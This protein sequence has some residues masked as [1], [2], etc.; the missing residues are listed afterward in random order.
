MNKYFPSFFTRLYSSLFVAIIFSAFVTFLVLDK[1]IE[2]D[3]W[4]DFVSDTM[5]MKNVVESERTEQQKSAAAFYSNLNTAVYPFDLYWRTEP[6]VSS[7]CLDCQFVGEFFGIEVFERESGELIA[8]HKM[9]SGWLLIQ[10]KPEPLV[11]ERGGGVEDIEILAVPILL[12]VIVVVIGFVL[13]LPIRKLQREILA[14]NRVNAEFGS[15]D[16]SVRA[17]EAISEPLQNL[18]KS[19][20]KMAG[21][22]SHRFDES[23][24]FAQAVPHEL[25]TPLSR[26]QLATG[27]LRKSSRNESQLALVDNIDQYI[28][29]IDLLCSEIIQLSK[30]NMQAKDNHFHLLEVGDFIVNRIQ[31]LGLRADIS[32]A[33]NV[34]SSLQMMCDAVNLRLVVDNLVKNAVAYAQ[35]EVQVNV[36]DLSCGLTLVVEDDGPG[37]PV[38]NREGVFLPFSR[39]DSSRN[40]KTG[41]L[42]LGLAIV[43]GAVSQLGGDISIGDSELGGALFKVTLPPVSK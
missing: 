24:I 17:D 36:E 30:L 6:L 29:D 35:S 43:K 12:L 25:R 27:I 16:M 18:A 7:K 37:V 19:F 26:I 38:K 21:E 42:G 23:Q 13:Y 14:L 31:Q 11:L 10:D 9:E 40:R 28:D 4:Q 39:L 32:I 34:D 33:V 22:L 8:V 41:G 1:W 2:Q 20:N 15:G 5:F 3:G